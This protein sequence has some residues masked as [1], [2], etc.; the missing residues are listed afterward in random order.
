MPV[1]TSSQGTATT[2]VADNASDYGSD[3]DEATVDAIFSQDTAPPLA[4]AAVLEPPILLDDH[5]DSKPLARLGKIRADLQAAVVE[6]DKVA[7]ALRPQVLPRDDSRDSVEVEY[8]E[9]NRRC[10]S[11]ESNMAILVGGR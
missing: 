4:T 2:I 8:D 10:F 3:L 1:A 9:R 5:G 6:L 7:A 11:R